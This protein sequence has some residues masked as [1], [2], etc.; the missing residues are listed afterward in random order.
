MEKMVGL[1]DDPPI[2]TGSSI[3]GLVE[4]RWRGRGGQGAVMAGELLAHAALREGKYF[5]AFPEFNAERSGVPVVA[6]TR[7]CKSP[8]HVQCAI[9]DPEIV[10]VLDSTLLGQVDV[11]AGLKRGP[12]VAKGLAVINS[13]RLPEQ[14]GVHEHPYPKV[15][16][17]TGQGLDHHFA[18]WRRGAGQATAA[19]SPPTASPVRPKLRSTCGRT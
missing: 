8:I 6:Y 12:H 18:C 7:I 3:S 2:N 14:R 5:Q 13:A 10:V 1:R 9:V 19:L 11:F 15:R 4:I 17:H 16:R